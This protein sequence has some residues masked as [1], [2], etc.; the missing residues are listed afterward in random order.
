VSL[1]KYVERIGWITVGIVV[2]VIGW[3]MVRA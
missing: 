3:L 2:A 1:R